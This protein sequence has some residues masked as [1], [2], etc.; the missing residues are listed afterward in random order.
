MR[1]KII[2]YILLILLTLRHYAN[3]GENRAEFMVDFR[4]NVTRIDQSFSDNASRI[5]ELKNYLRSLSNNPDIVITSVAFCGAASP[6]GSYNLNRS[7]AA[8]RLASL[9][10]LV[11]D[12]IEIP[13]SIISRDDSYIPWSYLRAGGKFLS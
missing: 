4:V 3:A 11:R 10:N 12:E 13:D 2:S 9:E 6:E 7:L 1:F 5:K 8:G